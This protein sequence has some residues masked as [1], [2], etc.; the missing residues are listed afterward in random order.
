MLKSLKY[1]DW[2]LFAAV[3]ILSLIGLLM[4]YSTGLSAVGFESRLWP[5]QLLFIV[6][7]LFGL[8]FLSQ[9]DHRYFRKSSSIIYALSLLL[10]IA[11]L[12]FG[13]EIRGARRW[14]D[15]G[16]MNFQ[17]SEFSKFALLL[18]L[19]K[20]FQ[21]RQPLMQKF[22]YLLWSLAFVV[23]PA[24]LIVLQ[25]D[26]GSA[27]VHG[28]IWFGLLL[29]TTMPRRF[30]VYLGVLLLIVFL[31]FWQFVFQ[32]Y[33]KARLASFLDPSADPLGQGY[34]VRQAMVAVG[35]GGVFGSG[36]ARGLQSQLKFLPE[37]QTDFIFAS[38]VEELG[39]VGGGLIIF[40]LLFVMWRI[41]RIAK[42]ARDLF[43]SYFASGI[44]FLFFC[45]SIINLGMNLGLLPVTG[46]PLPFVSYGGSSLVIAFWL[47]GIV[48]NIARTA[49]PVRFG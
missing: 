47:I 3:L 43:A 33:Q 27:L 13:T 45:Q 20:F 18:V 38:T 21:I 44:F 41:L 9:Q 6:I 11:V 48:E 40:L 8:F 42:N 34:N 37:R 26:L 22:S 46:I 23:L 25:P 30:F 2:L 49:A 1:F 14:F 7:G 29:M 28:A 16:F 39:L 15:L 19:A 4:I 35:S 36:L 17:P 31:V 12:F 10:L 32:D 24:V 5:R